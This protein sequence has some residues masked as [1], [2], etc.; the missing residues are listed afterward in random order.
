MYCHP[1]AKF[2]QDIVEAVYRAPVSAEKALK[3]WHRVAVRQGGD[4]YLRGWKQ[5][6]IWPDFVAM[7]GHSVNEPH[8]LVFE[9]KVEHLRGNEDTDYKRRVFET[10]ECAFNVGSMMIRDGPGKGTFKLIFSEEEFPLAMANLEDNH[11]V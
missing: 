1:R 4:Y 11:C 10:L 6:S 8:L 2:N 3:W 5:E 7:A 9:T